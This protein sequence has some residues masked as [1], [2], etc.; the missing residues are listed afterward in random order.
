MPQVSPSILVCSAEPSIPGEGAT[1]RNVAV[2]ITQLR[3][4][5]WDCKGNLSSVK[6]TLDNFQ[7]TATQEE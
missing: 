7:A 3:G 2:Y 5:Y 1:Q 6:E 4:A